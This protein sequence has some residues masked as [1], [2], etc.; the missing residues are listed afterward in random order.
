M[1]PNYRVELH[2]VMRQA[3]TSLEIEATDSDA[4]AAQAKTI[5]VG[6]TVT[7]VGQVS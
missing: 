3:T 6:F 7:S 4:A 2:H 5:A 1:A